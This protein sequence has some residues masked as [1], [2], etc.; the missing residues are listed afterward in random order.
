[1]HINKTEYVLNYQ[2]HY[3]FTQLR[4]TRKLELHDEWS[5]DDI[6]ITLLKS[7]SKSQYCRRGLGYNY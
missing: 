4:S 3:D 6:F 7:I 1:M 5:Q 2:L